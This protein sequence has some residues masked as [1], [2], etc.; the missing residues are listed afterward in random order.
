MRPSSERRMNGTW[1]SSGCD[2]EPDY[3]PEYEPDNEPDFGSAPDDD[4][5]GIGVIAP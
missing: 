4:D 5:T 3:E 2:E 1:K